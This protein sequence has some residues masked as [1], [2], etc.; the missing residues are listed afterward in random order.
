[1]I[2]LVRFEVKWSSPAANING[3]TAGVTVTSGLSVTM[4]SLV[5]SVT[6]VKMVGFPIFAEVVPSSGSLVMTQGATL[7]TAFA[8]VVSPAAYTANING[9]TVEVTASSG[10]LVLI[11]TLMLAVTLIKRLIF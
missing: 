9:L 10:L 1:M 3:F 8:K 4:E 2:I 6:L 5:L 7:S 11:K